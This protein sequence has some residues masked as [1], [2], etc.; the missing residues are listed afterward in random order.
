MLSLSGIFVG[1]FF[2]RKRRAGKGIESVDFFFKAM[3]L[4]K[5]SGGSLHTV[6]VVFHLLFDLFDTFRVA[7]PALDAVKYFRVDAAVHQSVVIF[8]VGDS[9]MFE[10]AF[11]PDEGCAEEHQ[12]EYRDEH[13][14]IDLPRFL[15]DE[16]CLFNL[17]HR[18]GLAVKLLIFSV[19]SVF[20][21]STDVVRFSP[22]S[23]TVVV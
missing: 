15:G 12:G 9:S 14:E 6:F 13:G 5:G 21:S 23:F 8:D 17:L 16:D 18:G 11:L 2:L 22:I 10:A 7:E 4:V 3:V 19:I 20:R 1:G